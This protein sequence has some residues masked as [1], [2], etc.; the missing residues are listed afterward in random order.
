M[1]PIGV[2]KPLATLEYEPLWE[3]GSPSSTLTTRGYPAVLSYEMAAA[4]SRDV[5]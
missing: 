5:Q 4:R 3:H 1:R 2:R